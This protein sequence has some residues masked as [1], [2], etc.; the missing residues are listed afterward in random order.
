MS[1]EFPDPGRA[2]YGEGMADSGRQEQERERILQHLDALAE[3]VQDATLPSLLAPLLA[4]DLTITQLKVL[5][6]LA[7]TNGG[8]TGS[9]LAECFGVS[10]ASVSGLVDRLVSQ[11]VA[12]RSED[13]QDLRVR[14]IHATGLGRSVVRQLVASRPELHLGVLDR[15]RLEDLR[16]LEQGMHALVKALGATPA[17]GPA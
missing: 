4:T 15:L 11:G 10:M 5:T 17:A 12:V 16:A 8:A 13:A 2:H 6:V 7:A 3:S 14:R 9:G 1:W